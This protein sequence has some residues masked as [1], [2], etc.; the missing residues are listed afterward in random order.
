MNVKQNEKIPR[1]LWEMELLKKALDVWHVE[2]QLNQL[3]EECGELIVA[4]NHHRR[5]RN[6][7][8]HI[9]EEL[10]DVDIMIQQFITVPETYKL[11][12]E[13]RE[14]K[15][16]RLEERLNNKKENN[17]IIPNYCHCGQLLMQ[18]TDPEI[19]GRGEQTWHVC[20][21]ILVGADTDEHISVYE[22]RTNTHKNNKEA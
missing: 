10:A 16:K 18:I 4:I 9:C 5:H 17:I 19:L 11:F 20:P 8:Q 14:R 6:T 22:D 13:A 1:A 3:Q 21:L 12:Q 15:L 7:W 2:P